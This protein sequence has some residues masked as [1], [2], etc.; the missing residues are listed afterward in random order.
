MNITE[1]LNDV[2]EA[3]E[4][5]GVFSAEQRIEEIEEW[6]SLGRM[7]I[8]SLLDTKGFEVDSDAFM[9]AETVQDFLNAIKT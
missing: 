6:D 3:I 7:S 1:L 4:Y 9:D 2:A 8:L 5:E